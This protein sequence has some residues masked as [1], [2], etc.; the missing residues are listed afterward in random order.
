MNRMDLA[1]KAN[2]RDPNAFRDEFNL[3]D[4]NNLPR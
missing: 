4:K 2:L 1:E 3:I